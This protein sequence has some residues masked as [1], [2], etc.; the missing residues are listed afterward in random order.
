MGHGHD[1]IS[2]NS[3]YNEA[4][5]IEFVIKEGNGVKEL[6]D[7]NIAFVSPCNVYPLR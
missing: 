2:P 4:E 6:T 7:S 5:L 3:D 1:T